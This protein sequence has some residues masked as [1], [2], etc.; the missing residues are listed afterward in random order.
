ML[1]YYKHTILSSKKNQK[2]SNL[3]YVLFVPSALYIFYYMFLYKTET[4]TTIAPKSIVLDVSEDLLSS[5]YPDSA[6]SSAFS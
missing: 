5:P 4:T 1:R 2:Q 6:R 3:I